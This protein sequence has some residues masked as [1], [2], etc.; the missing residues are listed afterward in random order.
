[1]RHIGHQ[2]WR[3]C[4]GETIRIAGVATI[5]GPHWV[6]LSTHHGPYWRRRDSVVS[7][8]PG[9]TARAHRAALPSVGQVP[10]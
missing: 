2:H 3:I 4:V 5:L 6:R 1:M 8:H 9:A 7:C 10:L